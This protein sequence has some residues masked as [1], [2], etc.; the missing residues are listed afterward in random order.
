MPAEVS[1]SPVGRILNTTSFPSIGWNKGTSLPPRQ[2]NEDRGALGGSASGWARS[3]RS[4]SGLAQSQFLRKFSVELSVTAKSKKNQ[5]YFAGVVPLEQ[6]EEQTVYVDKIKFAEAWKADSSNANILFA[7]EQREKKIQSIREAAQIKERMCEIKTRGAHRAVEAAGA[8]LAEEEQQ[9]KE[10]LAKFVREQERLT[11]LERLI[12]EASQPGSGTTVSA[13]NRMQKE[14]SALVKTIS[15]SDDDVKKKQKLLADAREAMIVQQEELAKLELTGMEHANE[16]A[17]QIATICSKDGFASD[18]DVDAYIALSYGATMRI[19]ADVAQEMLS[20]NVKLWDE[21][22]TG[23]VRL[24]PGNRTYDALYKA[25]EAFKWIWAVLKEAGRVGTVMQYGRLMTEINKPLYTDNLLD[26][27]SILA[28]R[29]QLQKQ[30][31][32]APLAARSLVLTLQEV[33]RVIANKPK[34]AGALG[35]LML[36]LYEKP[37]VKVTI[38]DVYHLAETVSTLIATDVGGRANSKESKDKGAQPQSQQPR[39]QQQAAVAAV[40]T[41]AAEKAATGGRTT[42][43]AGNH[44]WTKDSDA[45]AKQK[46]CYNCGGF[47]H[48]AAQCQEAKV[49][50]ICGGDHLRAECPKRGEQPAQSSSDDETKKGKGGN[51]KQGKGP[52][53]YNSHFNT[54]GKNGDVSSVN[55][56]A[57]VN[58]LSGMRAGILAHDTLHTAKA[59]LGSDLIRSSDGAV[60]VMVDNAAKRPIAPSWL[61]TDRRSQPTTL[62]FADGSTKECSQVGTLSLSITGKGGAVQ[63]LVHENVVA[64]DGAPPILSLPTLMRGGAKLRAAT[65]DVTLD[66]RGCGGCVLPLTNDFVFHATPLSAEVRARAKEQVD[67]AKTQAGVAAL[68]DAA[69][70]AAMDDDDDDDDEGWETVVPKRGRAQRYGARLEQLAAEIKELRA[71]MAGVPRRGNAYAPRQ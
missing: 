71:A 34:H 42:T 39:G 37:Y 56:I 49:C 9:L 17:S 45:N 60:G 67:S 14:K 31:E 23:A 57:S 27:P 3:I 2:G 64:C 50:Y 16:M 65:N 62:M 61:L 26:L 12:D 10:S 20:G 66:L 35:A 38:E 43:S 30:V 21:L 44:H 19:L 68:V 53:K 28:H 70:E 25:D 5:L 69:V 6:L 29:I 24:A 36:S 54:D 55:A 8:K 51:A 63:E 46:R 58:A 47:D 59:H 15:S 22:V 4:A 52:P 41:A 7:L 1:E 18:M 48:F 32:D 33:E 40:S 13:V 11:E